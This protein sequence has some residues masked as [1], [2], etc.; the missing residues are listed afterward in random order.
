MGVEADDLMPVVHEGSIY[1]LPRSLYDELR[2]DALRF[3]RE[4]CR[5]RA[6]NDRMST[7]TPH[8]NG[9]V[10]DGTEEVSLERADHLD[11]SIPEP[12]KPRVAIIDEATF[13]RLMGKMST[14]TDN[15]R[16]AFSH[17]LMGR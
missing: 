17:H 16:K 3:Y 9:A 2:G 5:L 14:T 1:H 13:G 10:P 8:V 12:V 4:A 7:D 6:A 15:A 11:D